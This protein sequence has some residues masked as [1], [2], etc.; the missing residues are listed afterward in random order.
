L[1][2][3]GRLDRHRWDSPCRAAMTYLAQP[4]HHTAVIAITRT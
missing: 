2:G 4:L 3:L 1:M